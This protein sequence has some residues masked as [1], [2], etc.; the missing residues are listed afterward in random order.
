MQLT[1]TLIAITAD[2][3]CV[4]WGTDVTHERSV[5]KL[6]GTELDRITSVTKAVG[7]LYT[8]C[9]DGNV[10]MYSMTDI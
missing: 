6:T 9:K 10:R 3:T 4:V 5:S 7:S 1:P 8:T 2:G